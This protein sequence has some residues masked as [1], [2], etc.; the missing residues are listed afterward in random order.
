MFITPLFFLELQQK[1]GRTQHSTGGKG[2]DSF[3]FSSFYKQALIFFFVT[4]KKIIIKKK[5]H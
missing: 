1:Y 4:K 2:N 3:L 5:A